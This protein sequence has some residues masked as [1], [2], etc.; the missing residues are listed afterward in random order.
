M[1]GIGDVHDSLVNEVSFAPLFGSYLSNIYLLLQL[2]ITYFRKSTIP[3][4][5]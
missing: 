5:W 2:E 3:N 4:E 1:F